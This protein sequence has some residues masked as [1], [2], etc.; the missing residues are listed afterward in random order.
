MRPAELASCRARARTRSA[1]RTGSRAARAGCRRRTSADR[2]RAGRARSRSPAAVERIDVL[3]GQRIPGDGVDG[4]VAPARRLV[5]RQVR[6]ARDRE[7]AM[8]A[9]G[10][11]LAARQRHVEARD[12]VD[13]EALADGVHAAERREQLLQPRRVDAEDLEVDVLRRPSQQAVAHPAADDQRAPAGVA[14]ACARSRPRPS[15]ASVTACAPR[16]P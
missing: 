16:K 12:L 3:A 7:A 15:G 2:P 8:P 10:L 4:E 6:I 14:D 9:A 11:R 1:R 5:E 13:G